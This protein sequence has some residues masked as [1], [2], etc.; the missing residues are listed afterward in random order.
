MRVVRA[1][2]FIDAPPAVVWGTVLD[3]RAY[4]QWNPFIVFIG[5]EA[6]PRSQLTV[7]IQTPG[8]KTMTLKPVVRVAEPEHELAWFG[9]FWVPGLLDGEHHLRIERSHVGCFFVQ[10]EYFR[11][12]L[13]PLYRKGF[14]A[15]KRGFEEMNDALKS[16]VESQASA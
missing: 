1:G 14:E 16:R 9:R 10:E 15:T 3:F 11:G 2:L 4:P 13:T 6:R 7:H 8:R 5:G 12:A